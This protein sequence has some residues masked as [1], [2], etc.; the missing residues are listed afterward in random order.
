MKVFISDIIAKKDSYGAD[1]FWIIARLQSGLEIIIKDLYYDIQRYVGKYV[2]VLLSILRSPY[3][4]LQRGIHSQFSSEEYYSVELIDELLERKNLNTRN[5]RREI[6]LTGE[7]ID[8]YVIPE[9]WV[10]LIEPK[11]FKLLLKNPSALKTNDGIFLLDPFNI[12]K[13]VPIEEFPREV[14]IA[15]GSIT[16]IAWYH[17]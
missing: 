9:R 15:T 1:Y 7:Y 6:I 14:T 8:S 17:L 13:K 3:L 4:E 16:L 11:S 5:H 10:P 12:R 2:E